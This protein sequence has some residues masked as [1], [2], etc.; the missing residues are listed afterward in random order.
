MLL[1]RIC[2]YI[3]F[4]ARS[5]FWN[6]IVIFHSLNGEIHRTKSANTTSSVLPTS[7]GKGRSQ[8]VT[9]F[10][11]FRDMLQGLQLLYWYWLCP[12]CKE[13]LKRMK[14]NNVVL[15]RWCSFYPANNL[16]QSCSQTLESRG[17]SMRSFL[18]CS[19]ESALLGSL[20]HIL[21]FVQ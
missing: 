2:A 7:S 21:Y 8:E 6:Q 15:K 11:C 20:I 12:V 3:V 10:S 5:S 18:Q 16:V 9:E 17:I 1:R 4:N 19:C 13:L 14:R